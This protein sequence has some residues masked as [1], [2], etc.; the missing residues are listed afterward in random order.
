MRQNSCCLC[1]YGGSGGYRETFLTEK[2][3]QG[4]YSTSAPS[5]SPRLITRC[6]S[7][8][9]IF[10]GSSWMICSCCIFVLCLLLSEIIGQSWQNYHRKASR[11]QRNVI[12]FGDNLTVNEHSGR[13]R[14]L[15]TSAV[16]A[17]LAQ[18]QSQ[19]RVTVPRRLRKGLSPSQLQHI[20]LT[21]GSGK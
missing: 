10:T 8:Q 5:V 7:G 1:G 20:L 14:R 11:W 18:A 13:R 12:T 3:L 19:I 2:G 17:D 16:C 4:E 6:S 15:R 9:E 21:Y